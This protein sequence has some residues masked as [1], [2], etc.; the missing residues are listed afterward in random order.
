MAPYSP[1]S[2]YAWL[3]LPPAELLLC[4]KQGL[5]FGGA[6]LVLLL[7]PAGRSMLQSQPAQEAVQAF[8]N[9]PVRAQ[10]RA[11]GAEFNEA[12]ASP[13]VRQVARW[14]AGS[15]DNAGLAYVILDK[16]Q[17]RLFLF[18]PQ[19]RLLGS[20]V[21][22]LGAARGDDSVPGI[23]N[24]PLAA[25]RPD[26]RT[27]PAGRFVAESG[28]NSNG[29][30]VIWVDY[31]AA[32]SMHRVRATNPSERRLQRLASASADDKRISWG[33]INVPLRFYEDQLSPVFKGRRGI[34]YVLPETRPLTQVFTGLAA[35]DAAPPP[36]PA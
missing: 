18:D 10:M 8:A 9:A 33:C 27:T 28:S 17:A 24:R 3:K 25:V 35:F 20:T 5:L 19:A 29:E 15:G 31:D 22:L 6:V 34:V 14:V 1:P 11:Q 30:D 23:G 21:V 4:L 13:A 7:P 16:S 2:R 12:L 32:V 26:E 36:P